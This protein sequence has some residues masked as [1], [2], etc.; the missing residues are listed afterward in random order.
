[1]TAFD[2]DTSVAVASANRLIAHQEHLNTLLRGIEQERE[3]LSAVFIGQTSNAYSAANV[4]W[5]QGQT[6]MNAALLDLA[7]LLT[8]SARHYDASDLDGASYFRGGA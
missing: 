3:Q 7:N 5:Q 2:I 1:M 4:Q 8:Q 6:T